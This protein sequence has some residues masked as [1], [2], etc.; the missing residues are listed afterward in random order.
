MG[1]AL[2]GEYTDVISGAKAKRPGLDRLMSGGAEFHSF[3]AITGGF[4]TQP[5]DNEDGYSTL[6]HRHSG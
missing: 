1:T 2:N 4:E 6:A 5:V 3:V